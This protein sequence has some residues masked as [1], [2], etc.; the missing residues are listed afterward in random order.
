M[1]AEAIRKLRLA[2]PFKPFL[3]SMKDGRRFVIDKPPFVAISPLGNVVLVATEGSKVEM[4][5][6]E[7]IETAIVLEE[8]TG[9]AGGSLEECR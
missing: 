2:Q 6:P 8:T 7:W 1:N 4:F 5:K 9:G 3:L